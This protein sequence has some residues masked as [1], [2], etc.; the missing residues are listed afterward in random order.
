MLIPA[1][2]R[3]AKHGVT[4]AELVEFPSTKILA[5]FKVPANWLFRATDPDFVLVSPFG[6][7]VWQN[8]NAKRSAAA[9]LSTGQVIISATPR[10][11]CWGATMWPNL[12]PG[13]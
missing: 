3:Q 9:E 1:F 11:T 7:G 6:R 12:L 13:G 10:W 5:K 4:M 2:Y 8:P